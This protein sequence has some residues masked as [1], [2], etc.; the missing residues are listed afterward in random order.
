MNSGGRKYLW[1]IGLLLAGLVLWQVYFPI[2]SHRYRVTVVIAVDGQTYTGSGV[3]SVKYISHGPLDVVFHGAFETNVEG[4]AALVDLGPRGVV[5][6]TLGVHPTQELFEPRPVWA[7][8]L[9]LAAYYGRRWTGA[10]EPLL[11]TIRSET[12]P[13]ILPEDLYPP[14]VWMPDPNARESAVPFLAR[15]IAKLIDPSA[16]VV[17]IQVELTNERISNDIFRKL[18]WLQSA[19]DEERKHGTRQNP[20][21][22][23]IFALNIM[24][25]N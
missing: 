2:Y 4:R 10:N 8:D 12:G 25:Y 17:S 7:A 11:K 24:G 9:G 23:R 18:P 20:R 13:R 15:D 5:L 16:R 3:V 6:A 21:N 14:L 19:W 1:P 22:F